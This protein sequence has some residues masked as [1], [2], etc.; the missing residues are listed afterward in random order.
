MRFWRNTS[1]A[2][3]SPGQVASLPFRV[4]GPEWDESIDTGGGGAFHSAYGLTPTG[5]RFRPAGLVHLS[6][7]TA[8]GVGPLEEGSPKP[9]VPDVGATATGPPVHNMTVYRAPSGA[10]VFNTA[11]MQWSWGL[12]SNHDGPATSTD[13]RMQQATVNVFA[14][15]GVQPATL[16]PGLVPATQ[17]TDSSAP[18]SLIN[19]VALARVNQP[20]TITGTALDTGG[21]VGG[22]EVSTDGGQTWNPASGRAQWSFTWTP[23]A[24]GPATIRTRAADDS[25]NLQTPGPGVV[26]V[27]A[28]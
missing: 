9:Q 27:V 5:A 20:V 19:P 23:T 7:T 16:R 25:A 13:V 2:Q 6:T 28:P 21:V 26:V 4:L 24:T 3:Q 17:T 1:I 18:T 10:L 22:V 12:D 14:D 11:T 15:M 8:P